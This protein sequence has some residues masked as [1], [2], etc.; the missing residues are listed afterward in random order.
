MSRYKTILFDADGTLF[1][2]DRAETFA[3]EAALKE[4]ELHCSGEILR[5]Y[6]RINASLWELLE[7]G[8]I[9]QKQ[10]RLQRF[11]MLHER[12]GY[13][14]NPADT[15]DSFIKFLSRGVFFLDGA[16]GIL[17]YLHGKYPLY[18]VTNGITPVQK[19]RYALS[20]IDKFFET[21]F[22]SEELGV[23]KPDVRYFDI[24]FDKIGF[25]DKAETLIIG[26]SLTSDIRGGNNAGI[27]TCWYNPEGKTND[28]VAV[29]TYEIAHLNKLKKIL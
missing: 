23:S 15:A 28:T 10:I 2:F 24:V 22:I 25:I 8:G 14:G 6:K 16:V 18:L 5:E 29:C 19:S 21:M 27:D 17:K 3:F 7:Q 20:G 9:T 13:R 4:N 12:F 26:D 11:E 1:D